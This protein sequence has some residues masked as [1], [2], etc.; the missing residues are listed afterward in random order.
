MQKF[1]LIDEKTR[2]SDRL[3]KVQ[4]IYLRWFLWLTESGCKMNR[5]SKKGVCSIATR[6][7]AIKMSLECVNDKT[8]IKMKNES[9]RM[10]FCGKWIQHKASEQTSELK[11]KKPTPISV[12]L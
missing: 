12:D 2:K 5:F 4:T 7:I 9:K 6:Q 11:K 3:I 10:E 1:N 8:A